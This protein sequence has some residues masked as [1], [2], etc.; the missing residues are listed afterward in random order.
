[1]ARRG[2]TGRG[3][4]R[5]GAGMSE[6]HARI[7]RAVR[8]IPRGRV[9]TYGQVARAAGM[10]LGARVVGQAM[11]LSTT[12]G[13]PWH[14]VLGQRRPGWAHV[15]IGAPVTAIRQRQRL[16]R[17]GVRF[18]AAGVIELAWFGHTMPAPRSTAIRTAPRSTAIRTASRTPLR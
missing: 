14:R 15:T 12:R 5:S 11:A 9:M 3:T 1:M 13:V 7:F 18:D 16:E 4:R 2:G 8:K 10:P 6:V 17:E